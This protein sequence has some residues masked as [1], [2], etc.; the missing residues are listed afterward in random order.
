MTILEAT[1][2]D[3]ADK[4]LTLGCSLKGTKI[5]NIYQRNGEGAIMKVTEEEEVTSWS[6]G[7]KTATGGKEA[8]VKSIRCGTAVSE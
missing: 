1:L 3:G 2:G 6:P 4:N 8:V 5:K 7:S